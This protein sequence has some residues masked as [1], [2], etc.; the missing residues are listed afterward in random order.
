L[1][2]FF[3]APGSQD[4]APGIENSVP[5]INIQHTKYDMLNSIYKRNIKKYK[6]KLNNLIILG[7]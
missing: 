5:H 4:L 7:I 2:L 6:L 3:L 1:A